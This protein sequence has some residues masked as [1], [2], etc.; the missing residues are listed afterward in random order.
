MAEGQQGRYGRPTR[1]ANLASQRT[2]E[3]P[4]LVISKEELAQKVG[5]GVADAVARELRQE[6]AK[7]AKRARREEQAR[8]QKSGGASD[9]ARRMAA[10]A[11]ATRQR[12]TIAELQARHDAERDPIMKSAIGQQIT[13]ER[14]RKAHL[15]GRI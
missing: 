9:L 4:R 15:E 13:Y 8:F 5:K 3:V 2:R 12:Q 6:R 1:Q 14:L 11:A 10:Q 7:R